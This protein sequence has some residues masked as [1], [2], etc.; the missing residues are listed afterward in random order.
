MENTDNIE[1]IWKDVEGYDGKYQ[2]S[3]LGRVKSFRGKINQNGKLL[4]PF[5][6]SKGYRAINLAS[7]W[8]KLHRLI[9]MTFIPN[10]ENKQTVNHIDGNKINNDISNL[11]WATQKENNK[12]ARDTG[13]HT[14]IGNPELTGRRHCCYK[15][16]IQGFDNMG[17]LVVSFRGATDMKSQ[18]YASTCVY[19]VING[20]RKTYKGLVYRRVSTDSTNKEIG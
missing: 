5:I 2:I 20:N 18:G 9:A 3:N 6:D 16:D 19:R 7:R 1:E 17:N 4:S 12:H 15:G 14:V 8:Y 11:E 10:P 13:L